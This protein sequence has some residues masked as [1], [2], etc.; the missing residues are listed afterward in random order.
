MYLWGRPLIPQGQ[1]RNLGISDIPYQVPATLEITN[2][3][4]VSLYN[5]TVL[6]DAVPAFPSGVITNFYF[7]DNF[8]PTIAGTYTA[9]LTITAMDDPILS[10]NTFTKTF[11]VLPG[12]SGI[13]TIGSVKPTTDISR[14]YLTIESAVN[15]LYLKGIAA[16][17]IFEFTDKSYT[18]NGASNAPA[19]DLSS[20]IIGNDATKTITFRPNAVN[21]LN[22]ADVVIYLNSQNG[23][24]ILLGQ[25]A[26]PTNINAAIFGVLPSLKREYSNSMGYITFDGSENNS[27]KFVLNTT[28]SFKA[29][30]YLGQGASHN[31][32]KNCIIED[33]STNAD[34]ITIPMTR[35]NSTN[36]AF[37]FQKDNVSGVTYS[38]GIVMRSIAPYDAKQYIQNKL[39]NPNKLDT[40]TNSYNE[41]SNNTIY[42]FGYGVVSLGI[43]VLEKVE[44]GIGV[45]HK[46]YNTAN[47]IKNNTIYNVNRAGIFL[48][49]EDNTV[50]EKNRIYNVFNLTGAGAAGIIAGSDPYNNYFGYNNIGL[51]IN[52]NEISDVNTN[53]RGA[54]IYVTQSQ[55]SY[56][57]VSNSVF[58]TFPDVA[59]SMIIV[60]NSIWGFDAQ[61]ANDEKAGIVVQTARAANMITPFVGNYKT[62][63]DII[64]NNTIVINDDGFASGTGIVG[65][66]LRQAIDTKVVNNAIAISDNTYANAN[67]ISNL[68]QY[69]GEMPKTANVVFDRNVYWYSSPANTDIAYVM[70]SKS[71]GSILEVSVSGSIRNID[72]WQILSGQDANSSTYN[73]LNDMTVTTSNNLRIKT[74]PSLPIGSKLNNNGYKFNE[75]K[76]N[77][78]TTLLDKVAQ[79]DL[80]GTLRGV[81]GTRVDVGALEFTGQVRLNDLEVVKITSPCVYKSA[82]G[83]YSSNQYVMTTAPVEVKALVRNN[84]NLPQNNAQVT[85]VI[86]RQ[87]P[88]GQ[89]LNGGVAI[90]QTFTAY[91]NVASNDNVEVNFNTAGVTGDKFVPLT[92][93]DLRTE[94]YTVPSQYSEMVT[95]VSPIYK[96][97]VSVKTDMDNYNNTKEESYRFYIK[98]SNLDMLVSAENVT[99]DKSSTT[100]TQDMLAGRLNY[101]SLKKSINALGWFQEIGTEP[102]TYHF[103][104]FDRNVWE[105]KAVN[106]A[107]Y[108]NLFWSDGNDKPIVRQVEKDIRAFLTNGINDYKKNLVIASQEM[109]RLNLDKTDFTQNILKSVNKAPNSPLAGASYSNYRVVGKE[110]SVD[111]IETIKAT[112]FT[113]SSITD[114]EP[115]PAL[116]GLGTT[117][118]LSKPAYMYLTRD[119]SATDS[120]AGVTSNGL[121]QNVVYLGIDWRHW[122]DLETLLRGVN[123]FFDKNGSK[124]EVRVPIELLD[125]DA[126]ALNN[127]VELSWVTASEN[128]TNKF[129]VERATVNKT[130]ISS[131]NVIAEEMA[132]GN[133]TTTKSYGP[134]IDKDV[135]SGSTYIYR[136]RTIDLNGETSL[137]DEVEVT[138]DGSNGLGLINPNPAENT[139]QLDFNVDAN[140]DVTLSIYDLSGKLVKEIFNATASGNMNVRFDVNDMTS[141]SYTIVMQAGKEFFSRQ[142]YVR[143]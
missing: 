21:S 70:E 89:Y 27:L 139:V 5:N 90:T 46:Y 65:L 75:I 95:N 39:E 107:I 87:W 102:K 14:N 60:N 42:G 111:K 143:K 11:T 81:G 77:N 10:N 105:P 16:S 135:A 125:F 7:T 72:Q 19:V 50:V 76:L 121:T 41:I 22:A 93:S 53:V 9:T 35:Y 30:F 131:F 43:G 100:L 26:A 108:K 1:V 51:K 36:R 96:I 134:V 37:E 48:G 8:T 115:I 123:D 3:D 15:D 130:G 141:G 2:S 129:E 133:S 57:N 13:Y 101:D 4:G 113:N 117:S 58:V 68:I 74:S 109:L 54:G 67:T 138:M 83:T 47:I 78:T 29:G 66:V 6:L 33:A 25:N 79:T 82:V 59:E 137:S 99:A 34:N 97:E 103:D 122:G 91:V 126:I 44:Q 104:V 17:V 63:N 136:L 55:N 56:P 127:R 112:G 64:A 132:A 84:G 142:L 69:Y 12:L 61:T 140:T 94:G 24:G 120:L 28:N 73:F 62:R 88:D 110:L 86:Y 124:I 23:V 31:T 118:S 40:L 114:A 116:V 128:N 20:R 106:Y 52:G 38:A 71:D 85:A 119:V 80:V 92:Y 32:I 18:V 49:F 98:R 45:H